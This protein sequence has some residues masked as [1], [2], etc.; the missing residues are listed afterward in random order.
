[1]ISN[2]ERKLIYT[3]CPSTP[4]RCAPVTSSI[5]KFAEIDSPVPN[6]ASEA[7]KRIS[8][9]PRLKGEFIPGDIWKN[10]Y[11]PTER[12]MFSMVVVL[13]TNSAIWL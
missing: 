10:W 4:V 5:D 2:Y 8:F 12:K 11:P 13:R 7:N 6:Y 3:P 1:M 9:L